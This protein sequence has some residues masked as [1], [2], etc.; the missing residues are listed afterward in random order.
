MRRRQADIATDP[1][2][3]ETFYR[4]HVDAITSFLTRRVDDPH[5]VADLVAEVFVAVL[6][7]AHTYR[8]DRGSEIA[9]LYGVARN[10]LSAE[11]RRAFKE[12]RLADRVGGMK[13]HGF[14][15][16][17]WPTVQGG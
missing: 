1:E 13:V 14:I 8:P 2:A 5:T 17:P 15:S 16:Q 12:T 7:T 6:D 10:T 3:F 9:W 11:R 4:R